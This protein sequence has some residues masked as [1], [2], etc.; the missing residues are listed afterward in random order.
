MPRPAIASMSLGRPGIHSLTD[1]LEEAAK[2]GFEGIELFYEDLEHLAR[3]L[4]NTSSSNSSPSRNDLLSAAR[5]VRQLCDSLHLTIICLQPF[6]FYEGLLSRTQHTHLLS[7]KLPLWFSLARILNTTTIQVPSNFLPSTL[8][9][10]DL[11]IIVSDLRALADLG[12]QKNPPIRFAYEALAWGTHVDT[13]EA[14]WAIV[15]RVNRPNFGLCL[16][17]FNIA[18]RVYADPASLT[19]K[20]ATAEADLAASI[21]RL[22]RSVDPRKVFYVQVVDGERLSAPL[23][24]GHKF[25]VPGQPARMSWSR[26]ARLFVGEEDRGGYLPVMEVAQAFLDIGFD[27]W[28]SMELFSRTLADPDPRTP[29]EHARR[30]IESWRK[31]TRAL[32]LDRQG[33]GNL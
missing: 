29:A 30:G 11:D 15:Q 18:G 13:W 3:K 2:H 5:R 27:G 32:K 26:N 20:T 24:E 12:A 17:T 7:Q 21:S 9:T 25:Y 8:A 1:K 31:L 10:G 16:D 19:G 33:S 14:S 23:V 6:S 4:S 22:R 28:V